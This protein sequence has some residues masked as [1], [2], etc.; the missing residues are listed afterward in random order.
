MLRS[1]CE[2]AVLVEVTHKTSWLIGLSFDYCVLA[3]KEKFFLF[4]LCVLDV[5]GCHSIH[6]IIMEYREF[7][8]IVIQL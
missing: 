5:Q 1:G 3:F 2:Y 6:F 4:V 7:V 8:E